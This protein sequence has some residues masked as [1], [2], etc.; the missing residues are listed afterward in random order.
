MRSSPSVTK[1]TNVI[2][3]VAEA[4]EHALWTQ[5]PFAS[6]IAASS[7]H[8]LHR[9]SQGEPQYQATEAEEGE[10]AA[11]FKAI[12]APPI[13]LQVIHGR[14]LVLPCMTLR[15]SG[16][17]GCDPLH[18]FAEQRSGRSIIRLRSKAV[19]SFAGPTAALVA[20]S[21]ATAFDDGR[22]WPEHRGSRQYDRSNGCQA[23]QGREIATSNS[24][25][26]LTTGVTLS[27]LPCTARW[28]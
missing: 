17:L 26:C 28:P 12:P 19:T 2:Q 22:W 8:L 24:A 6:R 10:D 16:R 21:S 14:V 18:I 9:A 20:A 11:S 27:G 5:R 13:S 4:V 7:V 15:R 23:A 1:P 25:P 3:S